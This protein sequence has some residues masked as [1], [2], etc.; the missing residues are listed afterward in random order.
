MVGRVTIAQV[1]AEVGVS[2]MTVSNVLNGRPGA[3]A[4]TRR[5][6][7]EAAGRL[8]YVVNTAARSLKNGRT[9]LVGLI[10]LDLTAQ[11]TLEI[12]RGVAEE[13]ADVELELL[14]NA[15]YHDAEREQDRIRSLSRGQV[16]GLILVAPVLE[17]A[18]LDFL[19]D[20]HVPCVV[21]DPRRIDT[22][23]PRVTVD[24][25]EGMRAGVEHL[26]AQGHTRIAFLRG[27]DELQSSELRFRG[28]SDALTLAGLQVDE[29]LV[30]TCS[31]SYDSGFRT[32]ASLLSE[33]PTAI[34]AGGDLIALGAI[35]AARAAGLDVPGDL[36]VLGFDDLPQAGQSFPGLTTVR[37]PLHD[38]GLRGARALLSLLDGQNLVTDDIRLAT[39]LVIRGS[40]GPA[41]DSEGIRVRP[42]SR[43]Q[44]TG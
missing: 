41:V 7:L 28:Y 35:D 6:V 21:I 36:S 31:F 15:S 32:S 43:S 2:A 25:Y 22:P 38:M 10:T 18:T 12:I 40:T 20:N 13:L 27:D 8:G 33:N 24:N 39:S 26:I 34:A 4:E 16:D 42:T 29:R 5:M 30:R 23:L 1:A 17:P 37:Q 14:I 3:S 9:G 44:T 19:R 11:Y